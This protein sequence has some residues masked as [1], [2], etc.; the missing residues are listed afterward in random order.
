LPGG[1][2]PGRHVY[3]AVVLGGQPG[4]ALAAAV[5]SKRGLK[6]LLVPHDGAG[7]PYVHQG[8]RFAHGPGLAPPLRAL[9]ALGALAAELGLAGRLEATFRQPALQLLT[10]G[11]WFEVKPD[12]KERSGE[13]RRALDALA[14]PFSRDQERAVTAARASDAFFTAGLDFPPEG[15]LARWR[16]NRQLPRFTGLA[17]P[18]PLP[19]DALLRRLLP[20]AAPVDR[21][22]PLGEARTL[23]QLLAGPCLLE[24]GREGLTQLLAAR[25]RELGADVLGPEVAVERFVLQGATA[26]GVRLRDE[27]ATFRGA[28][29]VAGGDLEALAPLVPEGRRAQVHKVASRLSAPR[30]VLTVHAVLPEA[31]LPPGLGPLGLLVRPGDGSLLLEVSPARRAAGA[32]QGPPL[33]TL[34]VSG[35]VEAG[36]RGSEASVRAAVEAVWSALEAVLPFTRPHVQVESVPWLHAPQVAGGHVEPWP[37]FTTPPDGWFGVTGHLTQPALPRLLLAGRQVFPGLGLE[38]EVLA[39]VRAAERVERLTA[40]QRRKAG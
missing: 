26:V 7:E 33:L 28:A 37:L 10:P 34:T 19:P 4:P 21:P 12:E 29:L 18:C 6:V 36:V 8:F 39:A 3:D 25:A 11:S 38:G 27:E 40:G 31:G 16:F 2:S 15:V 14:E 32:A 1:S 23:G 9:P 22:G 13:L 17:T 20:F 35:V 24:G 5:L 30:A